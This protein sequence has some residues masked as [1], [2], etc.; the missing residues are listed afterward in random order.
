MVVTGTLKIIHHAPSQINPDGF[1]EYR[2]IGE[3]RCGG[4]GELLTETSPATPNVEASDN[5]LLTRM[6][7]E[8]SAGL[9]PGTAEESDFASVGR[10]VGGILRREIG[11]AF[12]EG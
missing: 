10:W 9:S 3:S 5:R 2:L 6:H 11:G 1:T 12:W 7:P 4:E 8:P